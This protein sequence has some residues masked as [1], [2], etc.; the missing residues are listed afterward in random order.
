MAKPLTALQRRFCAEYARTSNGTQSAKAAGYG[1][2]DNS[3]AVTAC[4]LLKTPE[5]QT[6]INQQRDR[7]ALALSYDKTKFL[8][9]IL[10]VRD[11][12]LASNQLGSALKALELLGKATGCLTTNGNSEPK[13]LSQVLTD[14][15][16]NITI[17][18]QS[19]KPDPIVLEPEPVDVGYTVM[20]LPEKHSKRI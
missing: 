20:S 11:A 3:L 2:A 10:S 1:G 7:I 16:V 18:Q 17:E 4:K 8:T 13:S 5:I 15:A 19:Q 12:A 9:D 14:V 6:E